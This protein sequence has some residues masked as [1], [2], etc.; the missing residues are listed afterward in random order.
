MGHAAGCVE[1]EIDLTSKVLAA[2]EGSAK[3]K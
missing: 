1:F 2:N 3:T